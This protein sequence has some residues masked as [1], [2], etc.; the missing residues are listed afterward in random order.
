MAAGN[1]RIERRMVLAKAGK[2]KKRGLWPECVR[3]KTKLVFIRPVSVT[4]Y[5]KFR[6]EVRSR[7]GFGFFAMAD[8]MVSHGASAELALGE[9][10]KLKDSDV[11]EIKV[12]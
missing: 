3:D 1:E 11:E 5:Y 6:A 7:R 8:G 10:I 9:L 4:G 2:A 12:A